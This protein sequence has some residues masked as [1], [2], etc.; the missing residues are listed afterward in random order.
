MCR[1]GFHLYKNH[2]ACFSCRKAFKQPPIEDYFAVQGRHQYAELARVWRESVR[3]GQRQR[4]EELGLELEAFEREYRETTHKCPACGRPMIDMGKDFKPPRQS[5]VKAWRVMHGMYTT[6]HT[7]QTCGCNG[8]GWIPKSRSDYRSY[9][10]AQ[11]NYYSKQQEYAEE[12]ATT[13]TEQK[14][15]AAS[16]WKSCVDAVDAEL[17]KLK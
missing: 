3:E 9:L 6:G 13:T 5:D 4:T 11:R 10:T 12:D 14:C 7:F 16:Y 1:Y 8:P 17:T 15:S 2:F